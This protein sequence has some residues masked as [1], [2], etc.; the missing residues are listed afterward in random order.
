MEKAPITV[1]KYSNFDEIEADEYQYWQGRPGHEGL[2]ALEDRIAIVH[3]LP[4]GGCLLQA[5]L[6]SSEE[7]FAASPL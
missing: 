3:V 5:R 6:L 2:D 4:R 7:L 1:G